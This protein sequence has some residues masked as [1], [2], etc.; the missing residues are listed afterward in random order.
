[1][2]NFQVEGYLFEFFLLLRNDAASLSNWF[3]FD[4]LRHCNILIYENQHIQKD[5]GNRWLYEY[6]WIMQRM[7]DWKSY[8]ATQGT[9][10]SFVVGT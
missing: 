5:V 7:T 8:R 2:I 6:K 4:V 10:Y 9:L 3:T 1:M